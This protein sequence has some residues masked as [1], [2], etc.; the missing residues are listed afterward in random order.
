MP[1]RES[2]DVLDVI[3]STRAIGAVSSISRS[4]SRKHP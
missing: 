2:L 3:H 4:T 1:M